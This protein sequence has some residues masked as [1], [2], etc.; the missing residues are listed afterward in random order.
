VDAHR[1]IVRRTAR[2]QKLAVVGSGVL[3]D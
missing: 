1:K 2:W 3:T